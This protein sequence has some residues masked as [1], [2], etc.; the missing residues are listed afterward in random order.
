VKGNINRETVNAAALMQ[1]FRQEKQ[2]DLE[3][4]F[5][6]VRFRAGGEAEESAATLGSMGH[7][8]VI[9]LL[10][11]FV[12][13]SLQFR[14]YIEPFIVM[15]AIPFAFVGVVWGYTLIGS[16]L[17]SQSLLGLVSLAG[18]VVNDSI[19]LVIF[20][21]QARATGMT[22][23]EAVCRASRDRFRAVLLTSVTTIAGLIPIMFETSRQAQ[24]LIP[25]ATSI[26]F[27]ITASTVLV[28]VILPPIY[29]V[30][31]DFG[32]LRVVSESDKEDG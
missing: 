32:V 9:G 14:S 27:G 6:E 20:I 17:S 10:G 22:P 29:A 25:I 8:L 4:R 16:P 7:G 24:S 5:P 11:I 18:V 21:K 30:L 1:R 15:L 23:V 13:L 3:Q 19:L 26:V 31:A 2:P 12:L 28:L